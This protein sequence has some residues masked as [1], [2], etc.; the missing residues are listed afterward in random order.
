MSKIELKSFTL[1]KNFEAPW[2]HDNELNIAAVIFDKDQK[3]FSDAEDNPVGR[4]GSLFKHVRPQK[5]VELPTGSFVLDVPAACEELYLGLTVVENDADSRTVSQI[6]DDILN[7]PLVKTGVTAAVPASAVFP[8][9]AAPPVVYGVLK[10]ISIGLG[11]NTDDEVCKAHVEI[12]KEGI[13]QVAAAET[14]TV[15][16]RDGNKTTVP[17]FTAQFLVTQGAITAQS[18]GMP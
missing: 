14:V 12:T 17:V 16:D 10:L 18:A 3:P 11:A 13:V 8:V 7:N 5:T 1:N 9:S 15:K 4:K 2:N 6:V